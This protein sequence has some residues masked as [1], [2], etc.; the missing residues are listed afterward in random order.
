MVWKM[1]EYLGAVCSTDVCGYGN[2][3]GPPLGVSTTGSSWSTHAGLK[4]QIS[5]G[6]PEEDFRITAPKEKRAEGNEQAG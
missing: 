3:E 2:R 6:Q 1:A 4:Q 5:G